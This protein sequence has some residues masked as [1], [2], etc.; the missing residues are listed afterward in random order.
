MSLLGLK[1]RADPN[2]LAVRLLEGFMGIKR[3]AGTSAKEAL[4][5]MPADVREQC[6]R[7]AHKAAEYLAECSKQ[8]RR[9]Q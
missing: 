5:S 3:P 2:E 9:P 6:F 7:A 1:L 8:G 4:D